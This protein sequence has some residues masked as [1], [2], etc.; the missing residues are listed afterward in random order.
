MIN[1]ELISP[2]YLEQNRMKHQTS[3]CY[4]ASGEKHAAKI[5]N[6][7]RKIG[8]EDILDYGCGKG[9]LGA[10]MT[11]DINEYDPCIPGKDSP[12]DPAD[13][14]VCTD[15]MEHIEP[16]YLDA[17]LDDLKRLTKIGIYLNVA[18][19][20]ALKHL[21]DGRN[22]HLIQEGR[23]WWLP[24]LMKRFEL[25]AFTSNDKI[26]QD[27]EILSEFLVLMAAKE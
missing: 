4:G 19:Y 2:E 27:G 8:T 6:L 17:V 20:A 21:P 1:N 25:K 23:E 14:V 18:M 26:Q 15:V 3:E 24:R 22:T 11:F 12:P 7:A 10:A 16:E 5:Q 13:L 9:T